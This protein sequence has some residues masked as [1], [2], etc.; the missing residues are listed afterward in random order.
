[1][2][3]GDLVSDAPRWINYEIG[4]LVKF[5]NKKQTRAV[6]LFEETGLRKVLINE[7]EVVSENR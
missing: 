4:L 6:V 7:L 1:M 2:K 5:T 3:V